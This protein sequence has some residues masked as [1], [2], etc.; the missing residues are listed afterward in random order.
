MSFPKNVCS[1]AVGS[2]RYWVV[3]DFEME[4]VSSCFLSC[5]KEGQGEQRGKPH[6]SN[7]CGD[8]AAHEDQPLR[9]PEERPTASKLMNEWQILCRFTE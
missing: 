3:G 5:E 4:M 1:M 6:R 7:R 8:F 2:A 9:R